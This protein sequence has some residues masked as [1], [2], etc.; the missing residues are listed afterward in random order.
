[1]EECSHV[2]SYVLFGTLDGGHAQELVSTSNYMQFIEGINVVANVSWC[3]FD[4][5]NWEL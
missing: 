5:K 3:H 1:M 2:A 4:V